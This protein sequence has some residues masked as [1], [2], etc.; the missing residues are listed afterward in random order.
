MAISR[1]IEERGILSA[2]SELPTTAGGR[3]NAGRRMHGSRHSE[4][5]ASAAKQGCARSND[6]ALFD[7][8]THP[9][10]S[11]EID[12]FCHAGPLRKIDNSAVKRLRRSSISYLSG[13][14]PLEVFC[15]Y[16]MRCVKASLC[17]V[18]SVEGRWSGNPIFFF[19][20]SKSA[21]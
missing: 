18:E 7:R 21:I 14:F 9:G 5:G 19:V 4:T 20:A 17:A 3:P 10:R 12:C 13:S 1:I 2:V 8:L 6:Q 11:N 15:D 16:S